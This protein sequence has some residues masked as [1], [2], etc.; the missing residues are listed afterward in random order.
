MIVPAPHARCKVVRPAVVHCASTRVC[1]CRDDSKGHNRL[2]D[3]SDDACDSPPSRWPST[4]VG[5]QAPQ[6]MGRSV[7]PEM[8]ATWRGAATSLDVACPTVL[9][10][11]S[12]PRTCRHRWSIASL[13]PSRCGHGYRIKSAFDRADLCLSPNRHYHRWT[14]AVRLD[15]PSE[16]KRKLDSSDSRS[17][18][19]CPARRLDP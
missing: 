5:Q 6:D 2:S 8:S 4:H 16:S 3:R 1:P 11:R 7:S 18:S 12:V 15:Q 17:G 13:A 19:L 14:R 10:R 9:R